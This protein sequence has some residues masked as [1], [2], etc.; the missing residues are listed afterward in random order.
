MAGDGGSGGGVG[1]TG[2]STGGRGGGIGT[3]APL[4]LAIVVS[5]FMVCANEVL[6][7]NGR[8]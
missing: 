4:L 2:D 7:A 1:V 6:I 3:E 8:V 5:H